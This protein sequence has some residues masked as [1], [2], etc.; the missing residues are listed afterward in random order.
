MGIYNSKMRII[1]NA[2]WVIV[3][4]DNLPLKVVDKDGN[5]VMLSTVKGS[6]KLTMT[7]DRN[8]L[9]TL[10]LQ[11]YV[12]VAS[13]VEEVKKRMAEFEQYQNNRFQPT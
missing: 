4:D 7:D 10:D 5:E 3:G 11:L 8:H 6:R 12:N 9:S 13:S 2:L 1:S